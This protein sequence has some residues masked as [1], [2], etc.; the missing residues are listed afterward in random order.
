M[1]FVFYV[2]TNG[3]ILFVIVIKICYDMP[4]L[5]ILGQGTDT[6]MILH[7]HNSKHNG[8]DHDLF[9]HDNFLIIV[10]R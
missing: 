9:K 3:T 6:K 10:V 8:G 1:Q 5:I 7:L 4:T 2:E